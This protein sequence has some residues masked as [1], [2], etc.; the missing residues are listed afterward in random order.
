MMSNYFRALPAYRRELQKN[1]LDAAERPA[2][3]RWSRSTTPTTA[4]CA[5]TSAT[6]RSGS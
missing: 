4:S 5:R 1:E 2:S 6:I 3:T